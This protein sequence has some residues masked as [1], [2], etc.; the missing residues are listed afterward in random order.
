[1]QG[2]GGDVF[3][4]DDEHDPHTRAGQ[5]FGVVFGPKTVI[6]IIVFECGVALNGVEAAVVVGQDEAFGRD[7]FARAT[8]VEPAD[9]I[10]DTWLEGRI[11]VVGIEPK[12]ERLHVF[13]IVF[14][15]HGRQPHA[16]PIGGGGQ[17]E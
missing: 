6:Y 14:F 10:L 13:F 17:K 11:N 3:H 7:D 2:Q 5:F 15:Q 1:M 4:P 9:R 16:L 12:T 8:S